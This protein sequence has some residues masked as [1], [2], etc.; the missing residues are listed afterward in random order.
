NKR[1]RVTCDE[2]STGQTD[3]EAEA[4]EDWMA[5]PAFPRSEAVVDFQLELL[6]HLK[7][8]AEEL[9]DA[10]WQPRLWLATARGLLLLASRQLSSQAVAPRRAHGPRFVNDAR[11]VQLS[12]AEA[13]R[14]LR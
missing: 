13:L 5:Y 10:S 14:L 2:I 11:L 12:F 9:D 1:G 6:R 7:N 4:P 8:F 3:S